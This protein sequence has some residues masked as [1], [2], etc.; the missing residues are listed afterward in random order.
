MNATQTVREASDN[1]IAFIKRLMD[2]RAPEENPTMSWGK[3]LDVAY[4]DANGRAVFIAA[5]KTQADAREVIRYLLTCPR[6]KVKR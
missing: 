4:D 3:V 2:E 5:L 6:V 1:Q